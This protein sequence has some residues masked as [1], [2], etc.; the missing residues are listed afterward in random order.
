[1]LPQSMR[2]TPSRLLAGCDIATSLANSPRGVD[3]TYGAYASV[4]AITDICGMTA[5]SSAV[6]GN[7]SDMN[8]QIASSAEERS[9]LAVEINRNVSAYMRTQTSRSPAIRWTP[10]NG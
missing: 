8:A 9:V 5:C 6:V 3:R 4:G 1:M 2:V 7:V 10:V